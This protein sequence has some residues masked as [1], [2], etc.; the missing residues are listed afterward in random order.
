MKLCYECP[1]QLFVLSCLFLTVAALRLHV[2]LSLLTV[3]MLFG[4]LSALHV[5]LCA[6]VSN[7]SPLRSRSHSQEGDE[8]LGGVLEEEEAGG[9]GREGER[10]ASKERRSQGER[11][12]LVGRVDSEEHQ[13]EEDLHQRSVSET[14]LR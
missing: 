3:F 6:S 2:R 7:L 8:Q 11:E 1:F 14:D 9:G 10:R 4:L 5:L 13:D 12:G